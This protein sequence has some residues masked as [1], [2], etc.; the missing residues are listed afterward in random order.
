MHRVNSNFFIV[1]PLFEVIG[2]KQLGLFF[3]KQKRLSI[4][5]IVAPSVPPRQQ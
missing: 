1:A 5:Q 4:R 2:K 3:M